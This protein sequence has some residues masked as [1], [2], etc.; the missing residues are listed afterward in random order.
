MTCPLSDE[1]TAFNE[2]EAIRAPAWEAYLAHRGPVFR[3]DGS[4][5][6]TWEY[7]S[8]IS[9]EGLAIYARIADPAWAAYVKRLSAIRMAHP[10]PG[11]S[12]AV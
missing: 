1:E 3:Y 8:A 7:F 10:H 12:R 6:R 5:T 4:E 2:Y 9:R 11:R